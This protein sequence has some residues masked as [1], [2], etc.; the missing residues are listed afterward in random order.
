M[1]LQEAVKLEDYDEVGFIPLS[2]LKEAISMLDVD[3]DQDVQDF[4]FFMVYCKSDS[5]QQL[6]YKVLFELVEGRMQ[7]ATEK[8]GSKRPE[9]S[10]PQQI[11]ERNQPKIGSGAQGKKKDT[12]GEEEE[13]NYE[14]EFEKL[15]DQDDDEEDIEGGKS[16]S[17]KIKEEGPVGNTEEDQKDP[18]GGEEEE[19][20]DEYID[21]EEM[22]DVAEKCFVRI[23]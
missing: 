6:R 15:L 13:D 21:E 17:V 8:V 10:N 16:S 7:S 1:S 20:D 22:L 19:E 14:E 5:A 2:A 12:V 4:I 11:K 3:V 23:A 9:S 18:E